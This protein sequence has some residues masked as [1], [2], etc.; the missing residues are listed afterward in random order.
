[1]NVLAGG[2]A[3]TDCAV[4]GDVGNRYGVGRGVTIAAIAYA[5]CAR[6]HRS[7]QGQGEIGGVH[8]LHVLVE[9]H[10]ERDAACVRRAGG[11]RLP[12]DG[13][14]RRG[15]GDGQGGRGG[16]AALA[17]AVGRHG[18]E[19]ASASGQPRG[20]GGDR[21]SGAVLDASADQRVGT[22]LQAAGA[23]AF[24]VEVDAGDGADAARLRDVA[25]GEGG[26]APAVTLAGLAANEPMVGVP[27][28]M[29]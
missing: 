24:A 15:T 6:R 3:Q 11:R 8:V 1:M 2:E 22:D 18:I 20:R 16:G 7:A 27:V 21:P 9:V 5:Q 29:E 23:V 26:R 17:V 14:R 25:G 28:T 10:D 13:H 12:A 4:T 19:D